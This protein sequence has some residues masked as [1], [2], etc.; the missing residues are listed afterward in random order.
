MIVKKRI[1]NRNRNNVDDHGRHG[2][3]HTQIAPQQRTF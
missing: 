3:T 2:G 1:K